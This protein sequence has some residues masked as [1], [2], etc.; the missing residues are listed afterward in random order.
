MFIT[1]F[2]PASGR[3]SLDSLVAGLS[4]KKKK[5]SVFDTSRSDWINFKETEGKEYVHELEQQAKD[6]FFSPHLNNYS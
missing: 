2:R 5:A 3:S 6:G 1:S 4:A